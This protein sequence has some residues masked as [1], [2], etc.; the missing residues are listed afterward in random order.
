MVGKYHLNLTDI[1]L[2]DMI[3]NEVIRYNTSE[4]KLN[5]L[6]IKNNIP[7]N[8]QTVAYISFLKMTGISAHRISLITPPKQAVIVPNAIHIIGCKPMFIPFSNPINVNTPKPIVSNIKRYILNLSI[9]CLNNNVTIN[10][11]VITKI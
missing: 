4:F 10:P 2:T 8:I 11:V 9:S 3:T 1:T 6:S 7:P 5:F